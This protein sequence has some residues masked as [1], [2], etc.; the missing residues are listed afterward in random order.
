MLI[1][2]FDKSAQ[3]WDAESSKL[4]AAFRGHTDKVHSAVFSPDDQRVLTASDDKTACLW[5]ARERFVTLRHPCLRND[6]CFLIAVTV[7]CI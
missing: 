1:A 6:H 3:L 4:L 5:D 7:F 2:S